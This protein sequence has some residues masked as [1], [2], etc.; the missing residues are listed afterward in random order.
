MKSQYDIWHEQASAFE[1]GDAEHLFAWHRTVIKLLPDI[2][3]KAVLEIGCGRGDFSIWLARNHRAARITGVEFSPKAMDTARSRVNEELANLAFVIGDAESL[4]FASASFD[5]VI[6]CECLEHVLLPGRMAAEIARVLKP[7]GKFIVTT[8]NYFNGMVLAWLKSWATK[9]PFD[10]GS[11]VQPHEKFFVYWRVKSLLQAGGLRVEHMES[12][13]FQWLLLPRIDPRTLCTADFESKFW[14]RVFRPLGRHFTY[15]GCKRREFRI[16]AAEAPA[17]PAQRPPHS[18]TRRAGVAVLLNSPYLY[19]MERAVIELFSA[20]RPEIEAQF[21]MSH[22]TL[23]ENLPV[24]KEVERR[25]IPHVFM[26]DRKP[27]PRLGKPHSLAH[28][29]RM[30]SAWIRA[31]IALFKMGAGKDAL[32]ISSLLAAPYGMPLAAYHRLRG[33]R[34]VH[35]FHDLKNNRH[36]MRLWSLFVTDFVH[37]SRFCQ[38]TVLRDHPYL[39]KK[40]NHVLPYILDLAAPAHRWSGERGKHH[41]VMAGQI[42]PHKGVD[43]ALEAFAQIAPSYP[44]AT[45]DLVGNCATGYEEEFERRLT[46]AQARAEVKFWGYLDNA[47][48]VLSFAYLHLQPTP[49]SR[50]QESF[51]RAALEAMASG[52]PT[53]CF[54]S[55]GLRDMI[56]DGVTGIMC[57]E[58]SVEALANAMAL[59]LGDPEFRERCGRNARERYLREYSPETLR[60]RWLELL[61]PGIPTR[62]GRAS[63]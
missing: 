62:A 34:V 2:D 4:P 18:A 29:L 12:S 49:P 47:I 1:H 11:G 16:S 58:E 22:V 32:Y 7:E 63:A 26:P 15:Q 37:N 3:G 61:T 5:L 25:G 6:S 36:L 8:E 54:R 51:P 17:E 50:F 9:T 46:A 30:I 35:H 48:D 40:R 52:V 20:L 44:D 38:E 39:G 59:Y 53:L 31:S 23:R 33:R 42:S 45:L 14:K 27:W 56:E 10:S 19:G 43:Y 24:L 28:L 13:E 57:E 60:E 21:L 55:G 41:L